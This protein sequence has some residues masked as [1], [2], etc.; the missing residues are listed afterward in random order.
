MLFADLLSL[1]LITFFLMLLFL[2]NF[3]YRLW[4]SLSIYLG[5]PQK[6]L[7]LQ[8]MILRTCYSVEHLQMEHLGVVLRYQGRS[9]AKHTKIFSPSF[10]GYQDGL[11]LY[12]RALKTR[13]HRFQSICSH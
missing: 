13:K 5:C 4:I 10:L 12:L 6:Y 7:Q 11:S 8:D 3:K 9:H 1:H 2:F